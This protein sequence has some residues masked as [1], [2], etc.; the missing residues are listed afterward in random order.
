VGAYGGKRE[1]MQSVSPVGKVYQAG[2]LSGNPVAVSAGLAML[3][4]LKQNPAVYTRINQ[5]T[6][7]MVTGMRALHTRLGLPAYTI[8]HIG[9]MYT[10]FFTTRPVHNFEDAKTS[11]T[12]LFARYF[13]GMLQ[14]GFYLAPSQY[15]SLFVSAA[16][17]DEHVAQ[18]LQAHEAVMQE[19]H[20]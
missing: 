20:A 8:N 6:E 7:A 3:R 15:E 19:I 12:A 11:D 1:I 18:F 16:I 10:L 9:S 5:T 13:Q 4:H 17:T 14:R 2:T